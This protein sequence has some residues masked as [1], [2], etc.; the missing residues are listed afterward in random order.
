MLQLSTDSSFHFELL[1][2][3]ALSPYHGSDIGEVLE[4]ASKIEPGNME[5]FSSVFNALAERVLARAAAIDSSKYPVSARDA[6]FAASTYFR[7]A[8]FYLHGRKDDP[9]INE[10]WEK[11]TYAFDKAI[12]LLEIPGKRVMLKADE[13]EVP[14]IFYRADGEGKKPTLI[15]G[16]GYDGAQEEMLHVFGFAALERGWNVISCEGPGQPSVVRDQGLGFIA[17]W[18]KVVTPV[19]DYLEI[20]PEVDMGKLG[21]IGLSMG[22]Y[23]CVRAAAFEHRLAAVMAI[24]GVYDVEEAYFNQLDPKLKEAI[25][26]EG[27]EAL[28]PVFQALLA[29]PHLPTKIKWGIEQGLWSFN[30]VTIAGFMYGTKGMK[31][32]GLRDKVRCPILVGHAEDDMFFRGQPEQVK[33]EFGEKA[34]LMTL[35]SKDGAGEHCHVGAL[36]MMNGVVLNW[37]Q[38]VVA[39]D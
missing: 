7:S 39:R 23:L 14:A 22:G 9:R 30:S 27:S 2:V 1:R 31:L 37:F 28:E 38:G 13:F 4:A 8:D 20:L 21:L 3:L 12:A 34:T 10:L 5:S 16:N 25:K 6:Y 32:K 24:D 36:K 29:N 19:V 18:E 35:L 11:Q 33:E 17:E 26:K 15:V